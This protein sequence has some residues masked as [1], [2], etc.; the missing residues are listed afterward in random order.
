MSLIK[1]HPT[2]RHVGVLLEPASIVA[3]AWEQIDRIGS[4]ARW[5]PQR[6]LV[7]GAGPV[8]L[9]AA[10]LGKQRGLEV[11]VLDRI[12][13]GPKPQLVEDLG[14]HYHT[15]NVAQAGR[16]ADIVIECT[17]VGQLILAAMQVTPPNGVVCLTGISSGQRELTIDLT[18]LNRTMVLE[19]D[20]VFGSVNANRRHYELAAKT[21][22]AA[23][24]SWLGSLITRR[25]PLEHYQAALERRAGDVKTVLELD[26]D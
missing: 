10:L 16:D 7:T 24:P 4:R 5:E 6:V 17:G 12:T 22:A 13:D 15:S 14:G 23:D 2:L 18:S 20:V 1:L 9:L 19:N 26:G 25:E 21:L 11:H 3:K 8:G